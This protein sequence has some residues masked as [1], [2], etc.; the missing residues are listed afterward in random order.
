MWA[1]LNIVAS[2]LTGST[3]VFDLLC[4]LLE[5]MKSK[6]ACKTSWNL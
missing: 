1:L 3:L 2:I 6:V 5:N 4:D